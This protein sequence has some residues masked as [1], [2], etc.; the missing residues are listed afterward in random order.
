M[1]GRL[2]EGL[3]LVS[4]ICQFVENPLGRLVTLKWLS[5]IDIDDDV[6]FV[7]G[8]RSSQRPLSKCLPGHLNQGDTRD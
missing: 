3:S 1:D 2:G 8:S 6:G 7:P 4:T 5:V